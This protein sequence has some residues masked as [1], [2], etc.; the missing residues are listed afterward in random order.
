METETK[1]HKTHKAYKT[2]KH[3]KDTP[4]PESDEVLKERH[5]K[6]NPYIDEYLVESNSNKELDYIEATFDYLKVLPLLL[7]IRYLKDRVDALEKRQTVDITNLT[8]IAKAITEI[9]A[10]NE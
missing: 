10:K 3:V 5:F 9:I 1:T 6:N 8:I 7:E 4:D 2:P